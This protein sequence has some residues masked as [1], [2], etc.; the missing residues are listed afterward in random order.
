MKNIDKFKK[1]SLEVLI[2]TWE[3]FASDCLPSFEDYVSEV[4]K[5]ESDLHAEWVMH[6]KLNAENDE[7]IHGA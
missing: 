3:K 6:E 4:R 2:D 7:R 5:I 1:I